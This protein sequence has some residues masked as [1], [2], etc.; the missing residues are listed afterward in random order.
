[1]V[2]FLLQSKGLISKNWCNNCII[3]LRAK[4]ITKAFLY[5]S[6]EVHPIHTNTYGILHNYRLVLR[7]IEVL[8]G[9]WGK[10]K[11]F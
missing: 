9:N 1:M 10:L 5:R 8:L 3:V 4:F 7:I 2:E 6:V 11:I